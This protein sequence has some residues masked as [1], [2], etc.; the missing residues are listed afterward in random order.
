MQCV[1]FSVCVCRN[2]IFL[3]LNVFYLFGSVR[4]V[5][6]TT[7]QSILGDLLQFVCVALKS[8]IDTD[9]ELWLLHLAALDGDAAHTNPLTTTCMD[10]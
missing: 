5:T 8:S 10:I 1:I 6:T 9:S 3:K 2:L 4:A 7:F